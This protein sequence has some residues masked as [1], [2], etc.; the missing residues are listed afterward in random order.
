MAR[1]E[2]EEQVGEE[3]PQKK[4]LPLKKL[5]II[6]V[7][8]LVVVTAGAFGTIYYK[9]FFNKK[10]Q[11]ENQAPVGA[12]WP[13]DPFIVNIRDESSDRYLKIVIELDISDKNYIAEINQLKPKLRDNVLDLLSSKTYKDVMDISGKQRLREEIMVRLNSFLTGGK[14][15]KVYFTEFVIQ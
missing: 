3:V 13:M 12:I 4:K 15:V 7:A 8:V 9:K 2:K 1:E 11:I 14:I 10:E 6:G 5:I